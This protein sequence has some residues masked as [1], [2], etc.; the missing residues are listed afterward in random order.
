MGQKSKTFSA[1][2]ETNFSIILPCTPWFS[3]WSLSF[4]FLNENYVCISFLGMFNMT[5]PAHAA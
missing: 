2:H 3:M 1:N 4:S 5:R